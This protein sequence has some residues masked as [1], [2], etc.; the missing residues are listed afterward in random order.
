MR[1][2]SR[3]RDVR[4]C[5]SKSEDRFPSYSRERALTSEP[6]A[7]QQ[8]CS[9][10]SFLFTIGAAWQHW[11]CGNGRILCSIYQTVKY[12]Y[13]KASPLKSA[14]SEVTIFQLKCCRRRRSQSVFKNF[15]FSAARR[16]SIPKT[17]TKKAGFSS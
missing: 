17:T 6:S 1:C 2:T 9:R 16:P 5:A 14:D 7:R 8:T 13:L 15:L 3:Q 12:F 4:V 11:P 10:L